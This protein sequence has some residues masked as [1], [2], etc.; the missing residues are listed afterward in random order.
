MTIQLQAEYSRSDLPPTSSDRGGYT[1]VALS[2][3]WDH[4]VTGRWAVVDSFSVGDRSYLAFDLRAVTAGRQRLTER[5]LDILERTL[6]APCQKVVAIELG[7]TASTVAWSLAQSLRA[8]G[9]SCQAS[10]VPTFLVAAIHAHY[11]TTEISEARFRGWG[12]GS[13]A[14]GIASIPRPDLCLSPL[15][16]ST[17]YAVTRLL[18]DGHSRSE[19]A[20]LRNAS[21][22]T[23][24]NQVSAVFRKLG[25]S[26]RLE[27]LAYAARTFKRS[28][29]G[30]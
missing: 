21:T 15:L 16:T 24:A 4:L 26:G 27:L 12:E 25:V 20:A 8:M 22:R 17:E 18:A 10:R 13:M 19:I 30:D 3:I 29:H 9:F 14:F 6:S 2:A 1:P 23:V 5:Q 11:G 7:R 28:V